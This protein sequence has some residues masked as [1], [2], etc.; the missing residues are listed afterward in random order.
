MLATYSESEKGTFHVLKCKSNTN[1]PYPPKNKIVRTLQTYL[2][3]SSEVN[4]DLSLIHWEDDHVWNK[5]E[6]I[7]CFIISK[8]ECKT[9]LYSI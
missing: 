1:S 9:S 5:P 3:W 8:G 4:E 2:S 6:C 7:K